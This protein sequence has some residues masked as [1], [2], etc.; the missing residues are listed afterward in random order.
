[1]LSFSLEVIRCGDLENA[2]RKMFPAVLETTVYMHSGGTSYC[3]F[4]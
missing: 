1:M 4:R 3:A 2:A